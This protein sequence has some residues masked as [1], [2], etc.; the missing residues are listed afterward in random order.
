MKLT[1]A[2][3]KS[4]TRRA[5]RDN[6]IRGEIISAEWIGKRSKAKFGSTEFRVARVVIEAH[7]GRRVAKFA[8]LD[9]TNAFRI[10]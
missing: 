9:T 4:F 3:I 5:L 7:D 1:L 10:S 6:N 2:K 8:T